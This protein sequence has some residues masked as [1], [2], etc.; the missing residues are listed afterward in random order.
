MLDESWIVES[1]DS[2]DGPWYPWMYGSNLE[3]VPPNTFDICMQI[4]EARNKRKAES[5]NILRT[6]PLKI[7]PTYIRMRNTLS[8]EIIPLWAL[9]DEF[10]Y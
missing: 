10:K 8:G 1:G 2:E 3:L 5:K 4:V 9:D 7:E 6:Q